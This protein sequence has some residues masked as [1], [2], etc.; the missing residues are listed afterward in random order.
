MISMAETFARNAHGSQM[1]GDQPYAAH[2]EA[3]VQVLKDAGMDDNVLLSAAWLHDV[4]E[5]T[6]LTQ[7]D[8][9]NLCGSDVAAIVWACTGVGANRRERNRSISEKIGTNWR[10]ASVK[11]A[12]RIANVEASR[13]KPIAS[14]YDKEREAFW[15]HIAVHAY[16]RLADRLKAAYDIKPK[17][18]EEPRRVVEPVRRK[19]GV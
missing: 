7:E 16:W 15:D 5:D 13:G 12:D 4:I 1:Y 18:Y 11:T 3:V 2:L 8:I 17:Q 10:Y 6:E 14:M 9:A 19:E